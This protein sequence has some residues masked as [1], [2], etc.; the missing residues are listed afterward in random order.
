MENEVENSDEMGKK[1]PSLLPQKSGSVPLNTY[2]CPPKGRESEQ[3]EPPPSPSEGGENE[4]GEPPPTPP[5]EGRTRLR[6]NLLWFL[7]PSFEWT[8]GDSRFFSANGNFHSETR[9]SEQPTAI[10][11]EKLQFLDRKRENMMK[12][13]SF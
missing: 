3:R 11:N 8:A 1:E 13:S 6:A 9:I 7:L 10:S 5:K 4:V 2:P 12:N